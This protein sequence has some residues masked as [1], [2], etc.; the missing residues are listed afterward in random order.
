MELEHLDPSRTIFEAPWDRNENVIWLASTLCLHRNIEKFKFPPKL[1][2]ERKK[3]LADIITKEAL[4]LKELAGAY[5]IKQKSYL[6]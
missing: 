1:E 3:Q 5:S 4:A 6:L 2:V